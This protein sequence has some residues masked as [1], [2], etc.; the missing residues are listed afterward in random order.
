MSAAVPG[1]ELLERT[2]EI[3]AWLVSGLDDSDARWKPAPDRWCAL[4]V[5]GHLADIEVTGFRGRAEAML[6]AD[7]P[8]L[9]GIDP[10]AIAATGRYAALPLDQALE[11]FREERARSVTLLRR[12]GPE[13]LLRTGEHGDLG[14]ITLSHLLHEWPLHD[15]GHV[16]QIAELV[17][18]RRFHPFI[19]PWRPHYPMRP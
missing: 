2:P 1:L 14:P 16:R 10:D 12:L 15:L 8:R 13:D 4:E 5:V 11:R 17:R 9:P 6:A 7:H 3:V 18:A 19:G